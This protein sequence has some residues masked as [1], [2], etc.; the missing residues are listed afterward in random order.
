METAATAGLRAGIV[1]WAP[2]GGIVLV[3]LFV[4]GTLFLF[5]GA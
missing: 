5:S 1:R 3:V 4:I 2:L